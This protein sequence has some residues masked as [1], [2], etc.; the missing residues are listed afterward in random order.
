MGI[1]ALIAGQCS[2]I[3]PSSSSCCS[4]TQLCPTLWNP[5]DR[6]MP[7]FCVLHCL[8]KLMPIESVMPSK[9]LILCCPILLL[10]SVFPRIKVFPNKL[11]LCIRWP[12][13]QSFRY[14]ISPNE[15]SGLFSFRIDWFD[16]LA[17]QGTLKG[18]LSTTLW[19][20]SRQY[21]FCEN[22]QKCFDKSDSTF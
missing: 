1:L 2:L 3:K 21:S 10:P 9:H 19:K 11:P 22:L 17:F 8:L 12:K 20:L 6:I 16:Q 7:G 14:S 15:Y 4:V 13:Y 18:L 5:M